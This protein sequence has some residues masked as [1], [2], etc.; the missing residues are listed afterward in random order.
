MR[1]RSPDS[2]IKGK[3]YRAEE[4]EICSVCGRM[5]LPERRNTYYERL[6][7]RCQ[8]DDETDRERGVAMRMLRKMERKLRR[9]PTF[10]RR[11]V[12]R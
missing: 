2:L 10:K 9:I 4:V 12:G 6:C 8:P 5:Y 1:R 3:V 7:L 11:R